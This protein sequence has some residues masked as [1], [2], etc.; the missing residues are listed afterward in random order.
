MNEYGRFDVGAGNDLSGKNIF[1]SGTAKVIELLKDRGNILLEE[2]YEHK[3]P[4]DWRTKRPVFIRATEQWF[5][6]LRELKEKS[7]AS[8][9]DM[10]IIPASKT[11]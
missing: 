3:Y 5:I 2:E 1:T 4:Y 7:K 9:D 11:F 8:L 6:D 10:L